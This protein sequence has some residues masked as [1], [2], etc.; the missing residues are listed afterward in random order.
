MDYAEEIGKAT[1]GGRAALMTRDSTRHAADLTEEKIAFIYSYYYTTCR[2]DVSHCNSVM[3]FSGSS[4]FVPQT[5]D[6]KND[7]TGRTFT[8]VRAGVNPIHQP[9]AESL[10]GTII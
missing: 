7:V 10:L 4:L 1:R 9:D 6:T 8:T 5:G 3:R 2:C